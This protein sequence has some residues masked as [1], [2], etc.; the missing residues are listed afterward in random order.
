MGRRPTIRDVASFAGVGIGSVSAVLN[1][2]GRLSEETRERVR[3][4]MI[5]LSYK[6]DL[7]ASH[8]ARKSSQILGL[9]VS[10][11]LNPF[12]AETAQAMEEEANRHGYEMSL[13]TTSFLPQRQRSAVE[14]LLRA[15][16]AG[17][18]VITSE[19]DRTARDIL[20]ASGVP[21]IFLDAEEPVG[22]SAIVSVD[23]DG[24]MQRAVEHLIHLG[25]REL[26]FIRN[27]QAPGE[28]PFR[29][30]QLRQEGFAAAVRACRPLRL[31]V[32]TLDVPG[33]GGDAGEQ[34]VEQA[35]QKWRFTGIVA[36]TDT[37][38]MGA[39]RGLQKRGLR[40]PEDVSVVGFDDAYFCRFLNPPL[41]TVRISREE[42]SR[43]SVEVLLNA[44]SPLEGAQKRKVETMLVV[45]DSTAAPPPKIP[46][47]KVRKLSL[48]RA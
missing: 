9:V 23:V 48:R 13:M 31:K 27:S 3:A 42:L 6:P 38:A 1:N 45:R 8:L 7:Y 12:F 24:G 39:Y 5:R 46:V 36:I 43:I 32:H 35:L 16:V 4:A 33:L 41:T 10:N 2:N 47:A 44:N 14:R 19:H 40:I 18:A 37:V 11:L 22:N 17:V 30:H 21:S 25:H 15:R 29:S 26:L 20:S 28:P 34:A